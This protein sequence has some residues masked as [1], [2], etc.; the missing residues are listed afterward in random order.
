MT[1]NLSKFSLI[2]DGVIFLNH[3]SYGAC[4]RPVFEA[5]Q[6]W[7]LA[8]ERQPVEFFGRQLMDH[9]RSSRE[10]LAREMGTHPDNIVD[11]TNA[12]EGLNIVAQSLDLKPGD[13]V[14][15]SDHEYGALEKTW[16][17][18]ARRTG[19]VVKVARVP[20]PLVSEASFTDA[21]LAEITEKTRVLFLSHITSPTA[22]LFPIGQVVAHARARGIYT[23]IDG[24]HVP[25]HIPVSLDQLGADFYSGNCHKW[26]MTPKGSAFLY[27]RPELQ[28]LINPLVISH[29]WTANSKRPEVRGANGNSA[30]LEELQMRGTRDPAAWLSVPDALRFRSENNWDTVAAW[31]RDMAREA[32][33]RLAEATG[34]PLLSSSEFCAPQMVAIETPDVDADVLKAYL[35]DEHSIELPTFKWNDRSILRFSVQYY[36]SEEHLDALVR[37]VDR[38]FKKRDATTPKGERKNLIASAS[39]SP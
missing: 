33:V 26:L 5:Y 35:L 19:A 13:E 28:R 32:A 12:T 23:V 1:G 14:L 30:F 31:C 9:L 7:Q 36:N 17:Y 18:V 39:P 11:V 4:P 16:N 2:R 8:L 27:V 37:A 20:L 22:L 3:G 29:G 34:K 38:F 15:M 10:A 25:G 24:A 21:I 6:R